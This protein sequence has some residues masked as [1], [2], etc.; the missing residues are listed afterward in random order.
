[1]AEEG[2]TE[3]VI[4]RRPLWQRIAKWV[5]IVLAA[6]LVL[7]LALIVGFNTSPGKRFI[8]GQLA[9]YNT[10]SGINIRVHD[11]E[12]S[13]YGKMTLHGLEVRDAQGVFLTSPAVAI[14]WNPFAY[15]HSKIDLNAV[16]AA[17]IRMLRNP[18]L[19]PVPSDPNAPTI[20]DI[21]LT[22][23]SLKVDRF[24]LEPPVTGQR[25]ILRIGGSAQIAD[26]R[27]QLS[28]DAIAIVAPGVRGGDTLH[29]RLDA[30]PDQNRLLID[31]K[32]AAPAGG[33]VDSY[34]RLGKPM[35]LSVGGQGDWA[36]WNG[37][38]SGTLGGQSLI[39]VG[40]S[41]RD[42]TFHALGDVHPGIALTG[43]AARLT[44]PAIHI[45]AT[46]TLAARKAD[47]KVALSSDAFV[48][49][50]A[51]L[52]DFANSRFG[53]FRVDAKLLKPG[54]IAEN[55]S[56]RNVAV[57]AVLDGKFV[58]PTIAYKLSADS[59]AFGATGIEGLAAAGSATIN[60]DKILVPIHATA[61]RVTGLN[62]AA[63][64]LVT[65]LKVDGDIA[66]AKGQ[67]FSDNLHLR[68]DRIDATALILADLGSGKYT[69]A[70]KGRVN[71]YN[72]DGLGR[73]NLVTDA[74][75]VTAPGGGF[76]IKG[77][78]RIVTQKITNASLATQ[79]GGNAVIV[80]DVGY[81]PK[82]GATVTGL[83]MT[84][85][86][87]RITNG[88]GAYRLSDGAIRF[89]A[90]A[91]SRTYGPASVTATGTI[92]KPLVVLKAAHPGVGIGLVN[93]EAT[94]SGSAAGYQVRAKGG[95]NYGPFTAAVLIKAGKGPLAIDVQ[96][97]LV[98]GVTVHGA[99]VQT[100]AGPF[101]G[102]LA[103]N[104]SG[105]AGQV[106]LAAAGKNQRADVNLTANGARLPGKPPISIGSGL[107]RATLVMLPGGP[108]IN[109]TAAIADLRYD[110][111]LVRNAQAR[112][113]YVNGRGQAALRADGTS[114][115]PFDIAA[116]ANFTPDRI[117]ANMRGSANG[118]AFS[119]AQPAVVTKAAGDY[120]LAPAT[121]VLPQGQVQL[122]GRYG[123][124][125]ELHAKLN[126]MDLSITQAFA[127]SLGLGGK[128]TGTVDLSMANN[129]AIPDARAR[130]DIA[131]F[132]RTGALVVSDPVD[133]S[134]LG[135]LSNGGGA[136]NALI[137]RGGATVG[138]IQARI[139]SIPAGS[140]MSQRLMNAPIAGGIRYNGPAEVLW[141]LTGIGGQTVSGPIAIG[142]DF[143]GRVSAPQ[144]TGVIRANTLR[145]ENQA[146][147][148][149]ISSIA[150]DGRFTQS[151]FQLNK[152]SGKAGSGTIQ[153]SGSVGIDAAGGF[154]INITATLDHAQLANSDA[155][156][157]TVS[158]NIAVTNSKAA[159]GLIKGDLRLS[160]A[161][162]EVVRQGAAEVA[163]LTG[164]RR[165]GAPPVQP[166]AA[167][168]APTNWKL[169][170]HL[171]ADNQIFVSG[172]GLDSEWKTDMRI[173]GTTGT[174]SVV[175]KLQVVRGTFSFSGRRLTLSDTSTVVFNGPLLN[176]DLNIAA[177]TTVESVTA[178]INIGGTAQKPAIT[179]TSTP[180]LPQD[181]VLSRLLFG[182]SVTS[183]TPMQALQLASA[184]N[185]LRGST[186]GGF[187]P[188][189]KLRGASGLSNLSV[190]GADKTTGRGTA[191]SAGK[192]IS[193]RIYVEVI[194]DSKGFT[195]T[196]L[197][198]GLS[199]A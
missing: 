183:L 97:L 104:G 77:R 23:G 52:L 106:Q 74:K 54:A 198:I 157:A 130:I 65:N 176:P 43:P 2:A 115:V 107:V 40:L 127:P 185:G 21:D 136:V 92:A 6:L 17:E 41:A 145:Y 58:T 170:L 103:I 57:S 12:G 168:P 62:A 154:P 37:R 199:K 24:I 180:V 84:A 79:L 68:S 100:A 184:L 90:Q 181:E 30:V 175:G 32:L 29:L 134:L 105:L 146:F 67:V 112:I 45:D 138:R 72:V 169:D 160:A 94:L 81:D 60:A 18:A 174:P 118:I 197:T 186:G 137:K 76:G 158:G 78:V 120:V 147:G 116:Q 98:A 99:I 148:T 133:I 19:K 11:I 122:A 114:S 27:A 140:T 3:I 172:M 139:P 35:T 88:S 86:D 171:S 82:G 28:T 194:A 132:S 189:G 61:R 50:A 191:V 4:V 109:G 101:A 188:L 5:S 22:L 163:E 7:V 15:L 159:G 190:L 16:S 128:A 102:S 55:L 162:Y 150:I 113:S 165:K 9:A 153:A 91:W 13:I 73:I 25:H 80:A 36:A 131:G 63:G 1:M 141:T 56:G 195:Q 59:I 110:T 49:Q 164:V 135:T 192:Y 69:G 193:N 179:F 173:G 83:T 95:S 144:I 121:I 66:Y 126:G 187:S 42:G 71:D 10:A 96:Q 26:R 51:G 123:R 14:D 47:T 20:P 33:V 108:S 46:T 89:S 39:D 87:L 53:N 143:S 93:L 85:P 151:Q 182:A 31:L 156:A 166:E 161:R 155:A 177:D 8:A 129:A 111:T 142:A 44:E 152:F 196:Q 64:G 70:L 178:T 167:G 38:A 34:A 119:L 117:L 48:A 124:I 125:T 149:T 75:L